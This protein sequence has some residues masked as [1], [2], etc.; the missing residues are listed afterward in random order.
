MA[1]IQITKAPSQG[2]GFHSHSIHTQHRNPEKLSPNTLT[3]YKIHDIILLKK[4]GED[5]TQSEFN[6]FKRSL[7]NPVVKFK[8][9]KIT[10]EDLCKDLFVT[11]GKETFI[12]TEQLL[13]EIETQS[14]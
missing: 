10:V 2:G 3:K 13:D 9:G 8:R 6:A 14:Q 4:G 11:L 5:M 12:E 7:A 1:E